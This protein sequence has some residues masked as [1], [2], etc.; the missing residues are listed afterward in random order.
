MTT[1]LSVRLA[2][3]DRGWDGRV[4]DQPHLNG[5][6]IVHEHI[7]EGRDDNRER[8]A[9]GV[10]IANLKD[11]QPPCSRDPGAFS[12]AG[13]R[14][15]HRDPL[16]FRNL[17]SVTE[18]LPPYSSCPAP[19]RW[20]REDQFQGLRDGRVSTFPDRQRRAKPG[21][22]MSPLDRVRSWHTSGRRSRRA[23]P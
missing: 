11:W 21:G 6:C 15:E 7:R 10:L 23:S 20:M 2:W 4:C 3:H 9:S 17:P 16:E 13:Y 22:C 1:H 5:S 18:D 8:R 12:P 14:I 19:Y